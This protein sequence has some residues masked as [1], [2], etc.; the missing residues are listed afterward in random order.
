MTK[1]KKDLYCWSNRNRK[2]QLKKDV[3][4]SRLS[5]ET[6]RILAGVTIFSISSFGVLLKSNLKVN[7]ES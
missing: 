5:R 2:K 6:L 7:I 3:Y 1:K 4:I